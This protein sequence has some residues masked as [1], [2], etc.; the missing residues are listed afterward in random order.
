MEP[1]PVPEITARVAAL[2]EGL[3]RQGISLALIRQAADFYYYT[4]TLADGWLAV[5]PSL[6]PL[7]LVRRP[8]YRLL[9]AAPPWPLAFYGDL[10][11]IPALLATSG[12]PDQGHLGLELDVMPV[13]F[14]NRL[15]KLFPQRQMQDVSPLIRRQRMLKSA[16]EIEQMRRAA[17]I[18]DLALE[19]APQ[20]LRPG[21]SEMEVAAAL[22]YR[23]RLLGH[24]GLVRIRTWNLELFYGH[25]LSGVSGVQAAYTDTPSGGPGFS[26][27]F[28]QGAGRKKLAYGE[29]IS[30][31]V[32]SCFNG[33]VVDQT[34]MYALGSM[35]ER[36]WEAFRL[37]EDLYRV[38][39]DLARPGVLP[40]DIYQRLWQEVKDRG[41]EEYFM[42][43]GADRVSFL[44]HGLGLEADEYPL[45][46]AR[47][48]YPL[49]ADMVLAFEPKIFIP[50]IGMIGLEDTGRITP[51]G[52][53]WLTTTPRE[54]M[55][56]KR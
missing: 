3:A 46:T 7:L 33:Y 22:E 29:P 4:G 16:Y 6:T 18:L 25:I 48:P 36:A 52:V 20:L 5:S 39:E 56:I 47:F 15:Q 23:L 9:E 34:R 51:G 1:A 26:P 38:F 31:D 12:F 44:G 35:P 28:P 13:A 11:E 19:D 17:R 50:E 32:F 30:I 45:L 8:Q 10:K 42:G 40:G 49:A 21:V 43:R 41:W 14:Y 2:K 24:Q 54:V 55:V 37:I 53:D 27:A